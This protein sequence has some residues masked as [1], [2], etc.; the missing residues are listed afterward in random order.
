MGIGSATVDAKLKNDHIIAGSNV[1][2][3]VEVSGGKVEQHIDGIY[4]S[5]VTTY[6]KEVD[7]KKVENKAIIGKFRLT[8]SFTIKPDEVREIPFT[9]EVPFDAPI[10]AG[11]TRV[12]VQ[13]GLDIK[14]AVDPTDQDF[15]EIKPFP[16]MRSF[17]KAVEDLGFR[18]RKVQSEQ[19]PAKL[20]KRLPFV[21]EFEYV[22]VEGEF[23]GKLDELELIFNASFERN[24]EVFMEIDKKAKGLGGFLSEALDLDEKMVRLYLSRED[25]SRLKEK[26]RHTIN[27]YL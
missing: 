3:I 25:E 4:M 23:V 1:E 16:L 22:P 11:G 24:L 20:R 15:I 13:T 17:I 18:L 8:G 5:L 27:Q 6:F 19:A 2:G 7:D 14:L 21:Q 26:I 10:T 9:F 12:W